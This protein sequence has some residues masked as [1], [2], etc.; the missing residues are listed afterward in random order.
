MGVEWIISFIHYFWSL[1]VPISRGTRYVGYRDSSLFVAGGG[2]G[3]PGSGSPPPFGPSILSHPPPALSLILYSSARHHAGGRAFLRA[4][5][6]RK[7]SG[8]RS[9]TLVTAGGC[10]IIRPLPSS[11]FAKLLPID[12]H[13]YHI[14]V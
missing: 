4:L 9:S 3:S 11:F 6:H 5:S 1:S 8:V 2:G 10:D 7:S 13:P 14:Y 12:T